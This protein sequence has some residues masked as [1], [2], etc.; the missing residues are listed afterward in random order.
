MLPFISDFG[1]Y[2][3]TECKVSEVLLVLECI[4]DCSKSE[5]IFKNK[6]SS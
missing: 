6:V 5:V 2:A 1:P 3:L 4:L